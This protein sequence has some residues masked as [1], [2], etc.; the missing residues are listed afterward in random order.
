MRRR[1][2]DFLMKRLRLATALDGNSNGKV[3]YDIEPSAVPN[4]K[5]MFP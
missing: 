3:F 2:T 1:G 5:M 4:L